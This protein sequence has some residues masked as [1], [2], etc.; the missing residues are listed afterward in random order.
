LRSNYL[1]FCCLVSHQDQRPLRVN[2]ELA[3]GFF[4]KKI[5]CRANFTFIWLLGNLLGLCD[6]DFLGGL[7]LDS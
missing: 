5:N 1:G 4:N 3:S 7:I 2:P 6:P